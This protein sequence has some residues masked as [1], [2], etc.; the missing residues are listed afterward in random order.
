ML[1]KRASRLV[2]ET[3]GTLSASSQ[4]GNQEREKTHY[5]DSTQRWGRWRSILLKLSWVIRVAT[6]RESAILMLGKNVYKRLF[7]ENTKAEKRSKEMEVTKIIAGEVV[8]K[9]LDTPSAGTASVTS[10]ELCQ[11]PF[12]SMK[13]RGNKSNQWWT[14]SACLT[15]WE[16]RPLTDLYT[17][18][19]PVGTEIAAFG[20]Y[21]GTTLG[22]IYETDPSYV[23]WALMTVETERDTSPGL[24]RA[25]LYF[26]NREYQIAMETSQEKRGRSASSMNSEEDS[27][28]TDSFLMT[29]PPFSEGRKR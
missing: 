24:K 7:A 13:R 17:S 12:E 14:C 27:S 25:A 6:I 26:A 20:K 19:V 9:K 21:A 2:Q 23:Q 22:H 3:G 1:G 29:E 4:R 15:R 10:P 8:G 16:R 11:H 18:E 5:L 28:E